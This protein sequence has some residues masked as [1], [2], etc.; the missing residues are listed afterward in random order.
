LIKF[1]RLKNKRIELGIID[2]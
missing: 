1:Y 2:S